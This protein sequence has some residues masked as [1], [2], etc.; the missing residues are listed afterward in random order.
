MNSYEQLFCDNLFSNGPPPYLL[1]S[2]EISKIFH[3]HCRVPH[4]PGIKYIRN[5]HPVSRKAQKIFGHTPLQQASLKSRARGREAN[6]STCNGIARFNEGRQRQ[7]C[8]NTA[9]R[10]EEG[11]PR[12]TK[13]DRCVRRKGGI[14]GSVEAVRRGAVSCAQE[15]RAN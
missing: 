1:S 4:S 7:P 5:L 11:P 8:P 3:E 2:Q 15:S 14:G 9:G 12:Q 10:G 13:R 6:G